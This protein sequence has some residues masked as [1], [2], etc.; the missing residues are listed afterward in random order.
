MT[1]FSSH[2]VGSILDRKNLIINLEFSQVTAL[3][4]SDAITGHSLLKF[5]LVSNLKD[6]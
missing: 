3:T 4:L 5:K 2:S 6:K 1:F